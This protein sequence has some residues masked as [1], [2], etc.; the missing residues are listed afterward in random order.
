MKK[1]NDKRNLITENE[2][3]NRITKDIKL[4]T[5]LYKIYDLKRSKELI[6]V[7]VQNQ[8]NSINYSVSEINPKFDVKNKNYG[9]ISNEIIYT[10][11]NYEKVLIQ[12]CSSYD[13]KLETLL[14][15]KVEIENKILLKT[16]LNKCLDGKRT[17]LKEKIV[18][19]MTSAIENIK[20]KIKKS[21]IIDVG[22]INKLQD[23]QDIENEMKMSKNFDQNITILKNEL[24]DTNQKI[25]I[26]LQDKEND[27]INAFE[28]NEKG[29]S[30]EIRKPRYFKKIK[31][32]FV[33]RFNTYNVIIKTVILPINQRV[34]NVREYR[35]ADS[36]IS[37]FKMD[38]KEFGE[39]I[40]CVQDRILDEEIEKYY[41]L[42]DEKL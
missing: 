37:E 24:E 16:I 5:N 17:N 19:K 34:E 9:K 40:K 23:G 1:T 6:D 4:T 33:N 35:T 39:K 25:K 20:G 21:E 29:L 41:L 32:F 38:F 14:L 15:D 12:L 31:K 3:Y 2:I 10:M 22:L 28:K 27:I 18:K 8:L 30:T 26:L 13:E 7:K 36:Q 42:Q 11:N